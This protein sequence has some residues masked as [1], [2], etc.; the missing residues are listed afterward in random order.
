MNNCFV[1][2]K[3]DDVGTCSKCST[4]AC[5]TCIEKGFVPKRCTL[6]MPLMRTRHRDQEL[7]DEMKSHF[8]MLTLL[9]STVHEIKDD[10][11]ARGDAIMNI[12]RCLEDMK[13]F[14]FINRKGVKKLR[15][16]CCQKMQEIVERAKPAWQVKHPDM[17]R[18][19]PA[20]VKKLSWASIPKTVGEPYV[21]AN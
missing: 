14:F 10:G 7:D 4:R 5:R 20:L 17:V 9:L 15:S 18:R 8:S 3:P 19:A 1:C 13:G 21:F 16:I 2:H 12:I 6:C 11:S